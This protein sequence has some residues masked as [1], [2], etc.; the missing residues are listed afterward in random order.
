M[1]LNHQL[2]CRKYTSDAAGSGLKPKNRTEV[3]K[4]QTDIKKKKNPF[5]QKKKNYF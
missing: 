5:S 3:K 1:I 2:C 4:N